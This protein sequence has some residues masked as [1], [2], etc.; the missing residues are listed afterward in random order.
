MLGREPFHAV[1]SS[2]SGGCLGPYVSSGSQA[3]EMLV[4]GKDSLS[5]RQHR[6]STMNS[7]AS[8]DVASLVSAFPDSTSS[9]HERPSSTSSSSQHITRPTSHRSAR[10]VVSSITS[11]SVPHIEPPP[12]SSPS[13][14]Q[15][16]STLSLPQDGAVVDVK[17]SVSEPFERCLHVIY[18]LRA[19]KINDY[20]IP[21]LIVK[22]PSKVKRN[23]IYVFFTLIT[24]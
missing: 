13:F 21:R 3:T 14:H 1:D 17:K 15:T 20:F 24:V 5:S 4:D 11:D 8:A 23:Y 10:S 9:V 12:A 18:N 19:V 22:N 16:S 6:F 2:T 7:T